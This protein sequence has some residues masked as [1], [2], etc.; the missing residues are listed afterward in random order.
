MKN[1]INTRILNSNYFERKFSKLKVLALIVPFSLSLNN[2]FGGDLTVNALSSSNTALSNAT[3]NVYEMNNSQV[4]I[5][6][7]R[8]ISSTSSLT[9]NVTY[10]VECMYNGTLTKRDTFVSSNSGDVFNYTTTSVRLHGTFTTFEYISQS[11]VEPFPSVNG[12]NSAIE[13][14]PYSKTIVS[15]NNNLNQLL[16]LRITFANILNQSVSKNFE[17]DIRGT[18]SFQ[19]NVNL[20]SAY[21]NDNTPL[22]GVAFTGVTGTT[23]SDGLLLD[24]KTFNTSASYTYTAR[25]NNTSSA[26]GP[27]SSNTNSTFIFKTNRVV[28]RLQ[29]CNNSPLSG[30]RVRFGNGT[31]FGTW[32]FPSPNQTDVN[33]N[34]IAQFFSGTYSFE[35]GYQTSTNV[36]SN[37]TI[38]SDT[39]LTWNTSTVTLNWPGAISYG[40]SGDSRFFNKPSMELLPGTLNFNFRGTP[41]N[42]VAITI[43]GCEFNASM[44]K[45]INENNQPVEGMRF[46]PA[47]GGSWQSILPGETNSDGLLFAVLPSCLTKMEGLIS[48]TSQEMTLAQLI[49][50]NYTYTTQVL[51]VNFIDHAGNPITDTN[52]DIRRGGG[53]PVVGT[54]NSSGF[55][56]VNTFPI[57]NIGYRVGYNSLSEIKNFT[58]TSDNTIQNVYFQTGKVVSTCGHSQISASGWSTFTNGGE[59]LPGNRTFR[60][61]AITINVQAGKIN[62][63]CPPYTGDSLWLNPDFNIAL[64]NS[65]VTGNVSTNDQIIGGTIYGTSPTLILSPSGSSP[66]LTLSSNGT[67][68]FN[69]DKVGEY[70][71]HVEVCLPAQSSPCNTEILTILVTDPYATNNDPLTVPVLGVVTG[72]ATP[73]TIT[74]DVRSNDRVGNVFGGVTS[75]LS[76]PTLPNGSS[77]FR[78]GS[79]SV[80]NSGLINY[81]PAANFIGTDSFSYSVCDASNGSLCR[82]EIVRVR[83]VNSNIAG[84]S[85]ASD[86]L[87]YTYSGINLSANSSLGVLA[88]DITNTTQNLSVSLVGGSTTSNPGETVLAVSNVGTLTMQ[89][90]GAYEFVPATS[91]V[92]TVIFTYRITDGVSSSFASLYLLVN[93]IQVLPV[94]FS[95]LNTSCKNG[96]V[97]IEWETTSESNNKY[98]EVLKSN[99]NEWINIGR[100]EGKGTTYQKTLYSFTDFEVSDIVSVYKIKQVDFDGKESLTKPLI[101]TCQS[102]VK[103]NNKIDFYPNPVSDKL[104]LSSDA[105][106]ENV[107]ILNAN[108]I[109]IQESNPN[110]YSVEL[111][112]TRLSHGLYFV[113]TNGVTNKFIKE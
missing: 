42:Y 85:V 100:L 4:P 24:F 1:L 92:G 3:Y 54:F 103:Q 32:F 102:E 48:N 70:V 59:Y 39:T 45:A 104:I 108:G 63:L 88:N 33:G 22:A 30:G 83:V 69:G 76:I 18:S 72:G 60:N 26:V 13:L 41:N 21:S 89:S 84:V 29:T 57:S 34:S 55:V 52:G 8:S 27:Q 71:Y 23:N 50:N 9:D 14:F 19:Y 94:N 58:I 109:I 40:G 86:D 74:L 61:P 75:S 98:F 25:I 113:K 62:Y 64:V 112:L 82:E 56:E 43:E 106:I 20:L 77:T 67:Y 99:N 46:R 96:L 17:I 15:S 28:L 53:W 78:G 80:S 101:S 73:S 44:L 10:A 38:N 16:T 68:T 65:N 49:S 2:L 90:N 111:D 11:G 95:K 35:M 79:V 47:C 7:S 105:I 81:T 87:N 97:T 93:D 5:I 110:S 66:T 36:K 31:T 107:V 51:R 12:V 37:V 6:S 91:F